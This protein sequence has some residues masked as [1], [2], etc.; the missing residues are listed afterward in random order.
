[1]IAAPGELRPPFSQAK[2]LRLKACATQRVLEDPRRPGG[3]PRIAGKPQTER[4]LRASGAGLETRCRRGR[5]A[6][7]GSARIVA[8]R[9]ETDG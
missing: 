4:Q 6:H 5:L 7:T 9:E 2:S 8:A 1:M 3:L